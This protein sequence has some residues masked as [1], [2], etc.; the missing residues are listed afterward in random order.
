MRIITEHYGDDAYGEMC[1]LTLA[2]WLIGTQRPASSRELMLDTIWW[3]EDWKWFIVGF[4]VLSGCRWTAGGA[5]GLGRRLSARPAIPSRMETR[6][7]GKE[8]VA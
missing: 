6:A 2:A 5:N 4:S 8:T 1:P 3:T 7:T